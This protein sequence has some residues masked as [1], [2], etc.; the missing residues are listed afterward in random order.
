MTVQSCVAL[1]CERD[2]YHRCWFNCCYLPTLLQGRDTPLGK[3]T[4]EERLDRGI[5]AFVGKINRTDH[6][7]SDRIDLVSAQEQARR[8]LERVARWGLLSKLELQVI[9]RRLAKHI[10][11]TSRQWPSIDRDVYNLADERTNPIWVIAMQATIEDLIHRWEM[12]VRLNVDEPWQSVIINAFTRTLYLLVQDAAA[13]GQ[14]FRELVLQGV[15]DGG[16]DA[17]GLHVVNTLL[18]RFIAEGP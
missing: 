11:R 8:W 17:E 3:A 13:E 7:F 12:L 14:S 1:P 9:R 10:K 6:K 15:A 18:D 16:V 2:P 4:C 5:E